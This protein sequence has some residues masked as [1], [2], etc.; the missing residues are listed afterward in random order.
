MIISPDTGIYVEVGHDQVLIR[1]SDDEFLVLTREKGR[2][3]G[4]YHV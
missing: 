4:S 1:M 2:A 3:H